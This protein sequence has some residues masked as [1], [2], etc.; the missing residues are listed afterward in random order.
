MDELKQRRR[1]SLPQKKSRHTDQSG[2]KHRR[3]YRGGQFINLIL[4]DVVRDQ[5]FAPMDRPEDSVTIKAM[6]SVFVPTA[7]SAP[8]LPK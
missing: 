5:M 8:S 4:P 6:I 3:L 7:A 2:Q 1:G